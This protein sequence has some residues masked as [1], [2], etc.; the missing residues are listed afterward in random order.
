MNNGIEGGDY[1]ELALRHAIDNNK[2]FTDFNK[3]IMLVIKD[4][5]L[6]PEIGRSIFGDLA[7]EIHNWPK[8]VE[9]DWNIEK[10][11]RDAIIN[12]KNFE[13]FRGCVR[14]LASRLNLSIKEKDRI[15]GRMAQ[16]IY[17]WDNEKPI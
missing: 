12:R 8:D 7:R 15:F 17:D 6:S 4:L 9:G 14:G 1:I 11:I 13:R 2:N 5:D 16:E 10:A 3:R